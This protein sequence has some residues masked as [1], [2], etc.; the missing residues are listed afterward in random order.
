MTTPR[1]LLCRFHI[2]I[3]HSIE[4]IPS[5]NER[6][7]RG[8]LITKK[9]GQK[10]KVFP[11][12]FSFF[13]VD[14]IDVLFFSSSDEAVKL[15]PITDGRTQLFCLASTGIERRKSERARERERK[16]KGGK[17]ANA[18]LARE[19]M[20][21]GRAASFRGSLDNQ[22]C[23]KESTNSREKEEG[24]KKRDD[25]SASER[26][27][28]NERTSVREKGEKERE[29]ERVTACSSCISCSE[30]VRDDDEDDDDT[31]LSHIQIT[32]LFYQWHR[33]IF[34]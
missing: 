18:W 8:N 34:M 5:S 25:Y 21:V 30:R 1:D 2:I 15:Q 19:S 16:E 13:S 14:S 23:D 31:L 28:A 11:S 22:L 27:R 33:D 20:Y 7:A 9:A 29:K 26:K 4:H 24:E 10:R 6:H 3:V 12:S 32:Q 17:G